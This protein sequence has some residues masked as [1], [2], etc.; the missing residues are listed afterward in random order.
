MIAKGILQNLKLIKQPSWSWVFPMQS[1]FGNR[2][3]FRSRKMN[4]DKID[5]EAKRGSDG[6]GDEQN[7]I[8][9]CIKSAIFSR[10]FS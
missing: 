8:V 7:I 9:F 10:H 3:Y 2:E 5:W 1:R 6:L 4:P